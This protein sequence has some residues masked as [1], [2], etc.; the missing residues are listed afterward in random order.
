LPFGEECQFLR[1]ELNLTY[2]V[3]RVSSIVN[4]F[5][6]IRKLVIGETSMRIIGIGIIIV[7]LL[8]GI[9]PVFW[10]ML[11]KKDKSDRVLVTWC[12]DWI[13]DKFQYDYYEARAFIRIYALS[14]AW[15]LILLG[16]TWPVWMF[17]EDDNSDNDKKISELLFGP[18]DAFSWGDI[19][20]ME[21]A[22]KNMVIDNIPPGQ[23]PIGM[24]HRLHSQTVKYIYVGTYGLSFLS[25]PNEWVLTFS[26]IGANIHCPCTVRA[27]FFDRLVL[28]TI[29]HFGLFVSTLAGL[30][31]DLGP[32]SRI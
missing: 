14:L 32:T 15:E 12:V 8:I 30:K 4:S 10:G 26:T 16:V 22:F 13:A 7:W 2:N 17:R 11:I 21:A 19:L 20:D 6:G 9:V 24:Q 5:F 25:Y 29:G 3:L 18:S 28:P 23:G 27:E 31:I 1:Q